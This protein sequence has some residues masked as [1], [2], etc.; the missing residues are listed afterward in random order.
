MSTSE[1]VTILVLDKEYQVQCPPDQRDALLRAALELDQRMRTI[2]Q[3]GSVIGLE[4]IAIMAALNLSYDL[5]ETQHRATKNEA[6]SE[7]LE[8]L[9]NKVFQA[10]QALS[11]SS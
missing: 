4:R 7:D 11:S 5:L 10:L 2:R 8:R 6:N 1:T 3:G 9:D